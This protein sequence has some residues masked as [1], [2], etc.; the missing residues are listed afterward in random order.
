MKTTLLMAGVAALVTALPISMATAGVPENLGELDSFHPPVAGDPVSQFYKEWHYFTMVTADESVA[1][2]TVLS[3]EGDTSD[4]AQSI[5][6]DI[7]NYGTPVVSNLTL[8]VYPVDLGSWSAE[9][10]NVSVN[11]S[12]I[13]FENGQYHMHTESI[14]GS[15]VFDAQWLPLLAPEQ[16]MEIPFSDDGHYMN[17]FL[18]SVHLSVTGSL[19][20]NSGTE[21][22]VVYEFTDA[23]GYHDHN[24]GRWDWADDR[25]WDWGQVIE[26]PAEVDSEECD[27]PLLSWR[28]WWN[29]VWR[30]IVNPDH[31]YSVAILNMT[32]GYDTQNFSSDV[33]IWKDNEKFY[34]FEGEQ[35][36]IEHQM[37]EVPYI[38]GYDIPA[39]NVIKARSRWGVLNMTFT[40]VD[41][42]PIFLPIEGGYR[43][44]WE[45]TGTFEVSGWIKGERVKFTAAGSME[46]FGAPLYE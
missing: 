16:V 32:D 26:K 25:G 5:A 22:E 17:W 19:T 14:D 10:P 4:V 6:L 28:S 37:M 9:T 35:V 45:L 31:Q 34:A 46:Y 39:T 1:F 41:F 27:G 42:A 13:S 38:P 30:P 2:S 20:I 7:Q 40:T 21:D 3:F 15:V 44:I 18:S 33:K 8:D 43:I 12:S 29:C 24:W 36:S 23:R 11:A